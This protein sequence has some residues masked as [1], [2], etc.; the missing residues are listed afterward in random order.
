MR[1]NLPVSSFER[2]YEQSIA[3]V[4]GANRLERKERKPS[5]KPKYFHRERS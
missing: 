3:G 4:K 5:K 2:R 1:G